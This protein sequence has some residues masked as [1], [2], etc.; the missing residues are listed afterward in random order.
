MPKIHKAEV[1]LRPIVLA[2]NSPTYRLSKELARILTPLAGHTES[3]VNN[4]AHFTQEIQD[5]TL[6][7]DDIMVSF[8]VVSLFT[9][10]PVDKAIDVINS[11]LE[12]DE[13]LGARTTLSREQICYLTKTCLQ[14]TY[15]QFED[16]FYE[17][18]E[19]AAMG[20]PLSPVVANLYMEAF[21]ERALS[22]N[23]LRPQKWK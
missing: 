19:G 16:S 22:T 3:H 8:D 18:V 7:D 10:V 13:E 21:E 5:T 14:T 9:R 4:S 20:S 11:K 23:I 1:P 17:Q 12:L 15:F 6:E 2:V